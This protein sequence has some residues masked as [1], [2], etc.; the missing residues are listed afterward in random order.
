MSSTENDAR[1]PDVDLGSRVHLSADDLGGR[2][3]GRAAGGAQELAVLH[4]VRQTCAPHR[5]TQLRL[6]TQ[7][8][9]DT[10]TPQALLA[11]ERLLSWTARHVIT[12][13][14]FLLQ[15]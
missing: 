14:L 7:H 8:Q 6:C 2:V 5:H 9:R 10:S 15:T 12:G 11:Y 13:I 1:A 4:H 3:V